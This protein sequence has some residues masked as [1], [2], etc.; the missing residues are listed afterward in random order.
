MVNTNLSCVLSGPELKSLYDYVVNR[1]QGEIFFFFFYLTAIIVGSQRRKA[2][3]DMKFISKRARG[4]KAMV[5][6]V[7]HDRLIYCLSYK[8]HFSLITTF[9]AILR[10]VVGKMCT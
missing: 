8:N 10:K 7:Y 9:T 6:K 2:M 4:M 3:G 1:D 5:Q